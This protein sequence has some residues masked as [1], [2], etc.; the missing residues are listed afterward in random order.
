M[1][2]QHGSFGSS[3][4]R[5]MLVEVT[6]AMIAMAE[7]DET[8]MKAVRRQLVTVLAATG[9]PDSFQAHGAAIAWGCVG[10][11]DLRLGDPEDADEHM[12]LGYRYALVTNDLPILAGVGL[13][14]A[15]LAHDR[16]LPEDAAEILGAVSKLRGSEDL[17]NPFT[18]ELVRSLRELLGDGSESA[19]ARGHGSGRDHAVARVDPAQLPESVPV[20]QARRR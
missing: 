3:D 12:R 6:A 20:P 14:V 8:E 11:L 18:A 1:R 4:M 5:G 19:Y 17:T 7:D 13:W 15:A 2:A 16:G 10:A 9:L